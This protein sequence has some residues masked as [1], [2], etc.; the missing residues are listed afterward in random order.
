MSNLLQATG[1]HYFHHEPE[2]AASMGLFGS[3]DANLGDPRN[4]WDTNQFPIS[5]YETTLA[6]LTILKV[7]VFCTHVSARRFE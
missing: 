4:G 7:S 1:N 2:T 3:V 6:M 5:F